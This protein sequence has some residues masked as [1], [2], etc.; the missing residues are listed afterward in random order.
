MLI[1][2][3]VGFYSKAVSLGHHSLLDIHF[4]SVI[5]L[6]CVSVQLAVLGVHYIVTVGN[7]RSVHM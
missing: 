1:L 6:V 3:H 5:E 7:L 4:R 2:F